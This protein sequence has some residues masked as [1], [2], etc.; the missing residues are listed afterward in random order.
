MIFCLLC[1]WSYHT[2]YTF[3]EALCSFE[4]E[5]LTQNFNIYNNNEFC[6]TTW[7]QPYRVS[8]S[9]SRDTCSDWGEICIPTWTKPREC[10]P[11]L[12]QMG[13]RAA[14]RH[15]SLSNRSPVPARHSPRWVLLSTHTHTHTLD[16]LWLKKENSL[17]YISMG[18]E[19]ICS[20][21]SQ[22]THTYEHID[23]IGNMFT[24]WKA[25][26]TGY[27]AVY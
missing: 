14:P 9:V 3:K 12:D 24:E 27:P 2:I 23:R 21:T 22:Y 10:C 11:W 26:A 4:E 15:R 7:L 20:D 13:V 25:V 5:S 6:Q 1:F 19:W 18:I 17:F 8:Q 16:K